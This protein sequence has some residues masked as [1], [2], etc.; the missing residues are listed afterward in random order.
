MLVFDSPEQNK[1]PFLRRKRTLS[2]SITNQVEVQGLA[3]LC[4]AEDHSWF[5]GNIHTDDESNY[6]LYGKRVTRAVTDSEK[7]E[8]ESEGS[9]DTEEDELQEKLEQLILTTNKHD[10]LGSCGE[11]S[12]EE[13]SIA[14]QNNNDM[15]TIGLKKTNGM[16][17]SNVEEYY[18]ATLTDH[19][20]GLRYQL[21]KISVNKDDGPGPNKNNLF[22]C[23]DGQV[24]FQVENIYKGQRAMMMIQRH[25]GSPSLL[26]KKCLVYHGPMNILF[27]EVIDHGKSWCL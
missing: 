3:W 17:P 22:V 21:P 12:E 27:T 14:E 16:G 13:I 20:S 7:D 25:I 8:D 26:G 10:Q 5:Q 9:L 18:T 4:F 11:S 6:S 2:T 24:T 19:F 1:M 23:A 15:P